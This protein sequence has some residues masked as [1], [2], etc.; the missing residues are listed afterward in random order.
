MVRINSV[1]FSFKR[2]VVEF[3]TLRR[4]LGM[5]EFIHKLHEIRAEHHN[6]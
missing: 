3:D 5:I 1:K 4:I 6:P 2:H